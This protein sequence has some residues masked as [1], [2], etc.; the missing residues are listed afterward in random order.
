MNDAAKS[1]WRYIAGNGRRVANVGSKHWPPFSALWRHIKFPGSFMKLC[2]SKNFKQIR[3]SL[4]V[5]IIPKRKNPYL[6]ILEYLQNSIT[7]A[8]PT[9]YPNPF[10]PWPASRL[11]PRILF[12]ALCAPVI[13]R[14]AL[15]LPLF[16][17]QRYAPPPPPRRSTDES[18]ASE[19]TA[20]CN[21]SKYWQS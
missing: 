12:L 18:D 15:V 17:L 1:T 20:S 3:N 9:K 14:I 7:S 2:I 16:C 19:G 11:Q 8:M 5:Q 13:S 10:W 4:Q 6:K 21:I